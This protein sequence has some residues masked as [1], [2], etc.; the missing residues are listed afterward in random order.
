MDVNVDVGAWAPG[1]GVVVAALSAAFIKIRKDARE[2]REAERVGQQQ[3]RSAAAEPWRELYNGCEDQ[4]K[5]LQAKVD[6]QGETVAQLQHRLGRVEGTLTALRAPH[7]LGRRDY[8]GA[9][10]PAPEAD[11]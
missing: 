7:P 3:E 4:R 5:E 11:E 1:I 2:A 9:I 8:D 10:P 6:G